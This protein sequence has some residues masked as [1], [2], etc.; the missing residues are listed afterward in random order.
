MIGALNRATLVGKVTKVKTFEGKN[1]GSDFAIATVAVG[2]SYKD[3]AGKWVK[4][5]SYIPVI[6]RF[7]NQV[8]AAQAAEGKLVLV[9][10]Y[11]A[12]KSKKL[13]NGQWKEYWGV[14]GQ[15]FTVMGNAGKDDTDVDSDAALGVGSESSAGESG[16]DEVPF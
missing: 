6:L 3:R 9:D 11:I 8:K 7:E 13:A 16:D 15:Q 14:Q 10:G 12:A 5:T 1:G 2:R 4:D